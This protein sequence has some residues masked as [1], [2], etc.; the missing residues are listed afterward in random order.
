M[1]FTAVNRN[2]SRRLNAQPDFV[3][4]DLNH[5]DYD[6]LIDNDA[7]VFFS[8]QDQ[9]ETRLSENVVSVGANTETSTVPNTEDLKHVVSEDPG[10]VNNSVHTV[11]IVRI[12]REAVK[13]RDKSFLRAARLPSWNR[14]P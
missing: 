1:D 13:G 4:A 14:Q 9:H 5:S 10:D 7:L 6:V 2:F 12:T 3:A 8:R 11:E